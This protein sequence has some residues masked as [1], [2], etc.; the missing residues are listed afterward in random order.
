MPS[1]LVR[2]PHATSVSRQAHLVTL[3]GQVRDPRKRRGVRHSAAGLL[4]VAVSAVV[5][6]AQGFTAIGEWT[7][8]AGTEVLARL[9]LNGPAEESTFRRLFAALD[10]DELDKV[11]GTWAA[12]RA[13]LVDGRR[14][15]AVDGKT[16][17]GARTSASVAPHLVAA[18][19]HGAGLVLGQVQVA[20][21]SGEIP[22]ARTLLDHLDLAGAVV[23]MDALHTQ[24]DTAAKITAAGGDYVFTVKGNQKHLYA[25]LKALPWAQVPARTQTTTG[26]GRRATRTIKVLQRPAWIEFTGATQ[27]A[28]LR[29]AVTTGGRRSVETVYLITSAD[30]YA[31]DPATLATWTLG[32]WQIENRLHWVRDV[33][34]DEDRSQARTATAPRVMASIRNIAISLLRHAGHDNIAAARRHHARNPTRPADL[35]LTS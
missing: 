26:H 33:T 35:I 13:A 3:L 16:V 2:S 27:I 10:G 8:D 1:S 25:R 22:A 11:I 18:V 17:R 14:V 19:S 29:R 23:T 28:Q 7:R 12:T 6:G 15:I 30:A 9:G 21:R 4:A 20:A 24:H 32:H 31:A 34:F 5:A